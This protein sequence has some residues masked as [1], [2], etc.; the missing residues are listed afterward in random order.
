MDYDITIAIMN[1]NRVEFLDRSI[2]SCLDQVTS[3]LNQ[4]I[5]IIVIDDCS[6]DESL[7]FLKNYKGK[8]K[9]YKNKKNMGV[10]Y[11]SNLAIKK[12]QGTFFIRVDSD[13][14]L[15]RLATEIM[16]SI[17]IENKQYSYVY[18]DHIRIDKNGFKEKKVKLDSQTIINNHGAG[19][20]FRTNVVRKVGNYDKS[21]REGEDYDLI[22]RIN[23]AN[24][25]SFYLPIP[26]YRY[27]IHNNNI[28][29]TGNRK[30][31]IDKINQKKSMKNE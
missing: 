3:L 11:C 28:S 1:Y 22:S 19:I 7:S 16:S 8:I 4:K 14:Y 30:Y 17:L 21:L 15:G 5:E 31:Y 9:L 10:G 24:Y 6:T 29:K 12:A 2:R 20:M 25:N 13:D 23:D 26:L 27:Y 18:C